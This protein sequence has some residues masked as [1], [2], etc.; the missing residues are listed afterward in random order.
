MEGGALQVLPGKKICNK[1]NKE[2]TSGGRYVGAARHGGGLVVGEVTCPDAGAD[3]VAQPACALAGR[4]AAQLVVG[5]QRR[6]H[7]LQQCVHVP[8]EHL[9]KAQ[10]VSGRG[11]L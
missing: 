5:R 3:K 6:K 1:E 11:H 4:R 7:W 10:A 8:L 9:R 2:V